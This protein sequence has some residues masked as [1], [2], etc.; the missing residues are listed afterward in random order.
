MNVAS[1]CLYNREDRQG[2]DRVS[3]NVE[4]CLN[5]EISNIRHTQDEMANTLEQVSCA[6]WRSW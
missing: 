3:D 2:I 1:Q 6:E 5:K 4:N